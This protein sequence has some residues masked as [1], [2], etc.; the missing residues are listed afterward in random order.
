MKKNS[1]LINFQSKTSTQLYLNSSSADMYMNGSMKSH[2]CFCF[3]SPIVIHKNCVEMRLSIVNA[4]IP[5]SWYLINGTNN[6]IIINGTSYFFKQ[7]NYNVNSFIVEWSNSIGPGWTLSYDAITNKIKFIFTSSFTF[8]D[9]D[10]SIFSIIGFAK[11]T[12]SLLSLTSPFVVNFAGITRLHLKSE[13]FNLGNCDSFKK[14]Q[15][16]TLSIIPVSSI[17]SG[18]ILY[19]N[20]TQYSNIFKNSSIGTIGIEFLD[21]NKNYIDFHNIDWSCTLQFDLVG[22]VME[23]IDTLEDVYLSQEYI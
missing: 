18:Y 21:D 7:G 17:G 2:L 22:E 23:T 11:L 20:Y 19:H 14:S 10:N 12:T 13:T 6:N 1:N 3:N 16:R 9:G 4:Q 8:S 15:N 5:V